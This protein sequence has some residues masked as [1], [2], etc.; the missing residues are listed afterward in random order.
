MAITKIKKNHITLDAEHSKKIKQFQTTH[1]NITKDKEL[2]ENKEQEYNKLNETP[3]NE[4]SDE[5]LEYKMVLMDEIKE[6]KRKINDITKNISLNKYLL[7]TSHI[8]Y[9]YYDTTKKHTSKI[10]SSSI[11]DLFNDNTTRNDS[12]KIHIKDSKNEII[13]KYLLRVNNVYVDKQNNDN[14]LEEYKCKM[15]ENEMIIIQSEGLKICSKCTSQE[16][17]LIDSDKPSYKDPPRELSYFAYKRIN[18]FNEW[19]AQFQAKET[20]DISNDVYE[21]IKKELKKESYINIKNIKVS[22]MRD[23]LKKLDLNKYYEHAPHIIN[24]LS[25]VPPP[26]IDKSTEDKL[27]TMFIKI[28]PHWLTHCPNKRSNFLSYSYVLYKSLQ[29]LEMDDLLEH[30]RLLKSREKLAE[31]DIIWKK[32]CNELKWEFI[33]TI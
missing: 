13:N 4:L 7:D 8:L 27:R 32:I 24:R 29:L 23:I 17:F 5:L 26:S 31:Q 9:N 1:Q 30:F 33:K 28:Q 18:H 6:L 10:Q 20:T 21:L 3:T 15:C 14:I 2:L 12:K 22:K 11:L 25:G 16:K 19:L